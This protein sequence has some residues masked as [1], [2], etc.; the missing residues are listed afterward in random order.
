MLKMLLD[1]MGIIMTN[2]GNSILR[3]VC[4]TPPIFIRTHVSNC[5]SI[6]NFVPSVFFF[7]S[8]GGYGISPHIRLYVFKQQIW[9]MMNGAIFS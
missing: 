8:V 2:D 5:G 7:P 4:P 9:C 6:H 1:P 3:E